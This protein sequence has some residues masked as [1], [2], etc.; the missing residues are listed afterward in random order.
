MA[1]ERLELVGGGSGLLLKKVAGE[2]CRKLVDGGVWSGFEIA[3]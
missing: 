3:I 2:E 1:G